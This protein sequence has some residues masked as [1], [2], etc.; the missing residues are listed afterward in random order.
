MHK[1]QHRNVRNMKK[2]GNMAS[3]KDS[4]SLSTEIKDTK[5]GKTL[6]DNFKSL[7]VKTISDFKDD[8]DKLN[9]GPRMGVSNLR[10]KI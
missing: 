4:N 9:L 7:L 8:T 10:K 3:P 5:V 2:Q 1:P 6:D